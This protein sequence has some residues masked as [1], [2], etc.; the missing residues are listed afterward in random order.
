MRPGRLLRVLKAVEA[1]TWLRA[2]SLGLFLLTLAMAGPWAGD[3]WDNL[4][5][6]LDPLAGLGA[7]LAARQLIPEV[8]LPLGLVLGLTLIA[9][10]VFC[11]FLC[12][13]GVTV[14]IADRLQCGKGPRF[15]PPRSTSN[16]PTALFGVKHLVLAAVVGMGLAG[17]SGVFLAAPIP[18]VTRFY[19]L[20]AEPLA[21]LLAE[22]G[23]LALQPAAEAAGMKTLA[24]AHVAA[25][26]YATLWFVLAL[27]AGVFALARF[28]P[29]FWCR[30][31]CP[32]GALFSLV[33]WKPLV[34]RRVS[35]ACIT[36]GRC[37]EVCPMD[38]I[39]DDYAATR[40]AECI[41]CEDCVKVCPVDAIRFAATGPSCTRNATALPGR[42]R[43]LLAGAAGA[44][45]G[46]LAM[47]ELASPLVPPGL[48]AVQDDSVI[49]PPG[50]LPEPDF[51]ARCLRCGQCMAACPTNTLQPIWFA[52]GTAGIF[53]PSITPRRGACEPTCTACGHAC[54][55]GAIRAL[56][57]S[58]KIHAKVGAARVLKEKCLA[59]E[60]ERGC[61]VC[62]EVCPYNAIDLRRVPDNPVAVPFV[63]EDRCAGCGFCEHHCP[64]TGEKAIVVSAQGALRLAHGSYQ[65]AAEAEGL[66][67][68]LGAHKPPIE[69]GGYPAPPAD[70]DG[71]PP[72]FSAP[73]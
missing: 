15:R 61:L 43:V 67:L 10:R 17:V 37:A 68:S 66:Q 28:S 23:L 38:A 30:Y 2:A 71:L 20:V 22:A 14:D 24:Y 56:P 11:G 70:D 44:G 65:Q 49:R 54:P 21:R 60:Q 42:R 5:L 1:R 9:G 32:A 53:S 36:C 25:R 12:P 46:L 52:A 18:L 40:H 55:N 72:G 50:A 34:R 57:Q 7:M 51:L 64:V 48:G 45:A 59:W 8:L 27:F 4:F 33:S 35:D 63:Q 69:Q 31:L 19:A 41:A 16:P 13:M 26:R 39:P 6:R 73:D 29:R 62:D 3:P 58:D 47:A